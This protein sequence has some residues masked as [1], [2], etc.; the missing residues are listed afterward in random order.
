MLNSLYLQNNKM[1]LKLNMMNLPLSMEFQRKNYEEC[2]SRKN[3]TFKC[4]KCSEVFESLGSLNKHNKNHNAINAKLKCDECERNF[5]Y[6]WKL[7]A[8]IKIHKKCVTKL[9]NFWI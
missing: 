8:H 5:D 4:E 6:E 2:L 1:I 9:L 3:T 7:N